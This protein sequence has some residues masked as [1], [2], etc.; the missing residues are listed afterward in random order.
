MFELKHFNCSFF[1]YCFPNWT[2]F[3]N[4]V[5]MEAF[6]LLFPIKLRHVRDA[7]TMHSSAPKLC[8][9]CMCCQEFEHESLAEEDG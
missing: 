8:H 2:I 4:S 7:L 9:V 6:L 3:V 1:R 5:E